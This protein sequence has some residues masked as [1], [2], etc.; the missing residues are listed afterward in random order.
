MNFY[1]MRKPESI[2][3]DFD[4]RMTEAKRHAM[5]MEL[6]EARIE[7]MPE[8]ELAKLAEKQLIDEYMQM[9]MNELEEMHDRHFN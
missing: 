9:S 3:F 2:Q 8:H 4:R 1:A 5:I 6:V 7:E